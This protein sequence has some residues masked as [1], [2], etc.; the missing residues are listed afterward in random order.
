MITEYFSRVRQNFKQIC[1]KV[2]ENDEEVIVVRQN[3]EDVVLM[4]LNRYRKFT[5]LMEKDM[6]E[7]DN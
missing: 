4:S 2:V 1:D 6:E 7:K 3:H 5:K